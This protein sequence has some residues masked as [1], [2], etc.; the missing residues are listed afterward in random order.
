[1]HHRS[2]SLV[3]I[4]VIVTMGFLGAAQLAPNGLLI[5]VIA[6]IVI[7]EFQ[8]HLDDGVPLLQLTSLFAVLQWLV[9]PLISYSSE[10]T[11]DR[12][13]MYV[14]EATYFRFTIPATA[15]YIASILFVGVSVRQKNLL[16]DVDRRRFVTIGV[17]LNIGAT[18][19]M[20]AA[21]QVSGSLAFL[22]H[23][24][25]QMRYVG[26]IYFLLSG[27]Q[28]RYLFAAASCFQLVSSS[29]GAG[30]FHDLVL[31]VSII[32]CY[33]FAQKKRA[34]RFKFLMLGVA[35][36]ALFTI[37]VIKQEYREQLRQG[38]D[39]SIMKLALT[40]LTPGGRAWETEVLSLVITR[41]NQGWIISAVM[42]NVPENEPFAEGETVKEAILGSLVP[43]FLWEKKATAGGRENFRRFTGLDILDTT[44]MG[45]SPLGEAYANFG[46]SAGILF[47][48]MVGVSFA[49]FYRLMLKFC[50][51][52]PTFLFWVPLI[53]YQ[54]IKTETELSVV[55]NQ[56]TKGTVVAF[57]GFF[58]IEQLFPTR[59]R[60][61]A[62]ESAGALPTSV[63]DSFGRVSK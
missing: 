48:T 39:P 54:A 62:P 34:A 23:L 42:S 38:Q 28:L 50:L 19:S 33:W 14:A 11:I 47:M 58:L 7:F 2:A 16:L 59:I 25:S 63:F 55:I 51:N 45:I 61:A 32:F 18:A 44:S 9:G 4:V 30:M 36:I 3:G 52:H 35:S 49:F 10:A 41:L 17:L 13:A 20:L 26:A 37:Q 12:Y 31:W 8:K 1:M 27:H 56:L 15:F 57:I 60:Q 46:D 53:F 43:R 6:G 22:M 5:T 24:L 40:Y 29:L 21:S